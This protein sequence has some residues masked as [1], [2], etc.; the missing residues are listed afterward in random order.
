MN[1]QKLDSF[2]T[3]STFQFDFDH[4][5]DPLPDVS[6]DNTYK[7][8]RNLKSDFVLENNA[9]ALI[10]KYGV[11]SIGFLTLTF[12]DKVW[13]PKEAS[14]RFNSLATHFLKKFFLAGIFVKEIHKDGSLHFHGLVACG[15]K[16]IDEDGVVEENTYDIRSGGYNWEQVRRQ[17]YCSVNK[18][19]KGIWRQLRDEDTGLVKFGFGRH[20]LE[21]VKNAKAVT[22]YIAKYISKGYNQVCSDPRFKGVR[23]VNYV[24]KGWR[25]TTLQFQWI[26]GKSREWRKNMKRLANA[27]KIAENDYF[28]M[29]NVINAFLDKFWDGARDA[30]K[31]AYWF[32]KFDAP[33]KDVAQ[34]FHVEHENVL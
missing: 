26:G 23:M 10:E 31:W 3:A 8:V 25:S 2:P 34:M 29:K 28:S 14:R 4:K 33:F 18:T 21:P 32:T 12:P 11:N 16:F 27:C 22:K 13:E 15:Y 9:L 7:R 1:L 30:Q 20:N 19:L 24:G 6:Q 17:N 5:L